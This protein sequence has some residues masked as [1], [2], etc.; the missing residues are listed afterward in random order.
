M[1]PPL[2]CHVRPNMHLVSNSVCVWRFDNEIHCAVFKQHSMIAVVYIR[3]LDRDESIRARACGVKD[4]NCELMPNCTCAV[5]SR[6][7]P[8]P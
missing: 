4:A 5:R 6:L 7:A 2:H 8:R 1:P 3:K